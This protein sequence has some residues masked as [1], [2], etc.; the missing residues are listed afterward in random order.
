MDKIIFLKV[1]FVL[2]FNYQW[3]YFRV[4]SEE[5]YDV[6][7]LDLMFNE[8]SLALANILGKTRK[9][10]IFADNSI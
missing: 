10:Q 1:L 2:K 5:K 7:I 6:M 8:A 4:L 9:K 3:S